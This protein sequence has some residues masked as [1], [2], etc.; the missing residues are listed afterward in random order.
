VK[1]IL[2]SLDV[3]ILVP[4]AFSGRP[5][6]FCIFVCPRLI[7]VLRAIRGKNFWFPL[8]IRVLLFHPWLRSR[9]LALPSLR[10]N[11]LP[12]LNA[13]KAA[14]TVQACPSMDSG[15]KQRPPVGVVIVN[16]NLKDSLR[17]TILSFKKVNYPGLEIVVSDNASKD[18]SLEMLRSE[19]P[20]VHLLAHEKEL[21]YGKAASLGLEF[22]AHKTKYIFSTTNDVIV[23][24]EII[25]ILVDHAEKDPQ[26][27]VLGCKIFYY[28]KDDLLWG[29]GAR[30]HPLHGHSYHFG[31]NRKDH[32]RYNHIRECDFVTGCGYLLRSDVVRKLDYF[33]SDL[34]FCCEDADYC[35]RAREAG[36]KIMYIPAARMWHKTSTT[37]AKNRSMQLYYST[38]NSL[39]MIQRHRIGFYPL[40]LWVHFLMVCPFKMALFGLF[41]QP[42]NSFGILRGMRDWKRGK[43]GWMG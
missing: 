42:K 14:F 6:G 12:P 23:D 2:W 29:A 31:W 1:K 35:Y 9:F 8:S 17:E 32:P 21:G 10:R 7:R 19:F 27:A 38:R 26:A 30:I 40:S 13:G 11:V 24:P 16:H 5:F 20:E 37:L 34:I 4:G 22:F 15:Q 18:G 33:K 39:Y 36:Y 25:N 43:L 3:L 41:L 28:G